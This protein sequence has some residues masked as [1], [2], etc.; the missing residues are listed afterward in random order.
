MTLKKKLLFTLIALGGCAALLA[1]VS[2]L[3]ELACRAVVHHRYGVPGRS[4][5][6]FQ[7]DKELGATHRPNSYNSNSQ[8]NNWG[9]RNVANVPASKPAGALRI[10]CSGGSTTFCYNLNTEE[11]WP[12][13]L[14]RTLRKL[15]GHA[16]DE[17]WNGGQIGAAV[18]HEFI[19]AKRIIPKLKP[20]VV[21]IHTGV[22]EGLEADLLAKSDGLDVGQLLAEQRWGM[23]PQRL[24][25][26]RFLKQ[27]SVLVKLWDTYVK[28]RFGQQAAAEFRQT[29]TPADFRKGWPAF[30][31]WTVANQ[32]HTLRAYLR[33]LKEQQ[34]RVILIRFGDNGTDTLWLREGIHVWRENAVRV[35]REEGVTV[36]DLAAVMEAHPRRKEF[37]IP[38]GVHVSR[39]GA[40]FMAEEL[41]K[42]LRSAPTAVH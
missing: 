12:C 32:E 21:I 6:I 42:L 9:F 13:A 2:G 14:E 1:I 7:A 3:A 22:N 5:G 24:E 4:Y 30:H 8:I 31:P 41:A 37:F 20:D 17:V 33:F 35:A 36:C 16:H 38:S 23:T 34:C 25:Q 15:P 18:A 11:A 19:L 40:D 29:D 27:H 10:F 26:A 28:T 39:E